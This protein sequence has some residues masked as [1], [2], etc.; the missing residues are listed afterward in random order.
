M[1]RIPRETVDAVRE[2]TDIAE[3]IGR[4]VALARRGRNLVGLCPFHQE[5]TPSFNV[6]PDK[7]IY[8]CFG[9]QAGGDVFRFL[10]TLEGLSFVEAVKE[11]AAPVGITIEEREL[12]VAERKALRQ[13][14]TA[15]EVLDAAAGFFEAQL[16]TSAEGAPAREYLEG[17]GMTPEQARSARLGWAPSGWSRLIDH[18]HRQGFDPE[19]LAEAGVAR[20]RREGGGYYDTLRERVIV[21]IRDERGRVIA[22]GGRLLQGEGPKYLNTP[23]TRIYEKSKVLYGLDVA[24]HPI[25]Q[26]GRVLVVEGYFDVLSLQQAGYGEAVA[27]CGT[28]L[29]EAHLDRI[30]RLTRDVVLVMDADE[31]GLRAAERT[32]PL[33]V[34]AGI[35]PWRLDLPGGKD[36]DECLR[37]EGG[38]EAFATALERRQ[39]LF[40]WV[41]G[42]KLDAYGDTTMSR[43]RVLDELVPL[44]A[45][46]ESQGRGAVAVTDGRLTR[47]VA[48]RLAL[49]DDAV[50][51][52]VRQLVA[53]G[54]RPE[55]EAEPAPEVAWQPSRDAV[56]LLWLV[57]HRYDQVAD[58]VARLDPSVLGWVAGEDASED[59]QQAVRAA[60]A[61]L[62]SG[63]PV[64]TVI[65]D[66]ADPTMQ[67]VLRAIVARDKLYD[68]AE[69]AT[70]L[71]HI[72]DRMARP[73]WSARLNQLKGQIAR[74]EASGDSATLLA[75]MR[76]KKALH[77]RE[78]RLDTALRHGD[79]A[80]ALALVG[81][82]GGSG[83]P[84]AG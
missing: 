60:L 66:G 52:R 79:V 80:Q 68:E 84:P 40:E 36:P 64:A 12:T 20:P 73:R 67:R 13:R 78:K 38:A 22:F 24:R 45:M 83:V 32:L 49:P 18:L 4:H 28:A 71:A 41:V 16:W 10:M 74:A 55:A 51:K 27:T 58:L 54:R 47:L 26:R 5:K 81:D 61:R 34:E 19:V 48:N 44:L 23:E 59:A 42:R 82:P 57:V 69:A 1:A 11:L 76:D 70:A 77:E 2:R 14:A 35:Q 43:E 65:E 25:Q 7:G 8:H 3:V 72:V 75:A 29:T 17:R 53:T 30:R 63:E 50:V 33:F 62:V 46:L 31:A 37:A 15:F 21:P 9:C 6:I 39:P 56:H